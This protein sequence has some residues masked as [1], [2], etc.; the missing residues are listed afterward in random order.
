VRCLEKC[1]FLKFYGGKFKCEYY[2]KQLEFEVVD[3][4]DKGI[5]PKRC[6]ECVK[7]KLVGSNDLNE[8]IKKVKFRLGLIADS[9]YSFKDDLE[10]ELTEIYRILKYLEEKS[11]ND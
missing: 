10:S 6:E 1:D 8:S 4:S 7:E 2:N 11:Q 3:I 9:F 5:I